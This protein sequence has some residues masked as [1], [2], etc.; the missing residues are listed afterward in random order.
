MSWQL[1][2]SSKGVSCQIYIIPSIRVRRDIVWL[3]NVCV[4]LPYAVLPAYKVASLG[5]ELGVPET[6]DARVRGAKSLAHPCR[7]VGLVG[8]EA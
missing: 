4:C 7:L 1:V 8:V 2:L 3:A 6:R 5:M